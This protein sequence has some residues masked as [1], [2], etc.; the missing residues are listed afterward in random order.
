[1]LRD[2]F[3]EKKKL[4]TNCQISHAKSF[5]NGKA[6][7]ENKVKKKVISKRKSLQFLKMP[8]SVEELDET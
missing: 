7:I 3:A 4:L 5:W 8:T 1:M 2:D 6:Q